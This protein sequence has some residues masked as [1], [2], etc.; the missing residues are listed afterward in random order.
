M[1]K[2]ENKIYTAANYTTYMP[3]DAF[4]SFCYINPK[5]RILKHFSHHLLIELHSGHARGQIIL[6]HLNSKEHNATIIEDFDINLFKN[7]LVS[8]SHSSLC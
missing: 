2:V 8:I 3:C 5:K 7:Q 1:A 4:L 6:D